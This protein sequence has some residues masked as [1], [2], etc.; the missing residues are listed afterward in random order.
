LYFIEDCID[1]CYYFVVASFHK[2]SN[3]RRWI[4][5]WGDGLSW[6]VMIVCLVC[7]AIGFLTCSVLSL[8]SAF[9]S[10]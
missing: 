3:F 9:L 10:D 5:Y 8:C 7:L 1:T 6:F 4:C 2:F